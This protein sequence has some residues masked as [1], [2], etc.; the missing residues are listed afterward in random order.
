MKLYHQAYSRLGELLTKENIINAMIFF[1]QKKQND[2]NDY[3]EKVA[4]YSVSYPIF[5]KRYEETR[6]S[7]DINIW[8]ERVALLSSWL[9]TIPNP[10]LNEK[11]I[12]EMVFL[13]SIF[14]HARL[15]EVGVESYL[16]D[17]NTVH[18]GEMIFDTNDCPP[19]LLKTFLENADRITNLNERWKHTIPTT[20]KLLH[21][22]CPHLFPIFDNKVSS[23]LFGKKPDY[24]RYHSYIF[25]L[26][27]LLQKGSEF[28]LLREIAKEKNVSVIR[29]VDIV[30]FNQQP[31]GLKTDLTTCL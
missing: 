9:P 13:E 30:L 14:H 15:E 3:S 5:L 24:G 21:F 16:G 23:V 8:A 26:R 12:D 20:T 31:M 6:G 4:W 11:A 2:N 25:A 22:M 17:M 18:H 1:E 19:V 28:E 7:S 29:V 10:A 27:E